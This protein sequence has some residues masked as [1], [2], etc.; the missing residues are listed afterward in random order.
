MDTPEHTTTITI[1]TLIKHGALALLGGFA[2]ALN[3][4]RNGD[5]KGILDLLALTTMSSF[6]GLL[7]G[8]IALYLFNDNEYITLA[9]AGTGGWLGIEGIGFLLQLLKKILP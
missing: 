4:H 6:F 8:F 1:I 9:M 5:G 7:F 3:K 2:H